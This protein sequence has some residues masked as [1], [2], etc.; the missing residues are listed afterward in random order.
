M[1]KNL[2]VGLVLAVTAV[3]VVFVS[4]WFDLKLESVALLGVAIGAVIALVPDRSPFMRLAA[5]GIGAVLTLVCYVLRAGVLPDSTGGFAVFA[6]L[7]VV[8]VTLV[9]AGSGGRLPLWAGLAGAAAFA[10]SFDFTYVDAP[11]EVATTS[12][13]ALTALIITVALGFFAALAVV[14]DPPA[15]SKRRTRS[16]EESPEDTHQ[17][18]DM[19]ET[20]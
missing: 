3:V 6:G 10:G 13:S 8:L 19:M 16:T 5:F 14:L 20:K 18:N 1:R 17:L 9:A 2:L 12:V 4:D 15:S 7:T 11:P